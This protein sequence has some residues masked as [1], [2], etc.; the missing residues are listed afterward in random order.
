MKS[1]HYASSHMALVNQNETVGL[2]TSTQPAVYNLQSL[3][4]RLLFRPSGMLNLQQ[5]INQTSAFES[6]SV[7]ILSSM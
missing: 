1:E 7:V 5:A 3:P 4:T 2:Y 6:T